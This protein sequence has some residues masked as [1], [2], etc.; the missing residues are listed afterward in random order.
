MLEALGELNIPH[1]LVGPP[2]PVRRVCSL[3]HKEDQGLYYY[4]GEAPGPFA[5][6]ERSVVMC[7]P[8]VARATDSCSAIAIEGAVQLAFYRICARLFVTEPPPGVHPTAIIDPEAR[9][10]AAVHIGPYAVIGKCEIGAGSVVKAHVVVMDGSVIGERVTIE[11]NSCIGATGVA[12]VWAPDGTRIV[13]PQLGGVHIGDEVFIGTDVTVVRGMFNEM[14]TIGAGCMVAHGSKIGHS[15]VLG[16]HCHLANNVSIAGSAK[17]GARSFL[18]A[19]CSIRPHTTLAE[20]TIVGVG[21]AVV[22]DSLTPGAIL[23]GVPARKMPDKE[24]PSG[25]PRPMG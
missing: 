13:L 22:A 8:E 1:R 23:A 12:W 18:G 24:K 4:A 9:I 6:L 15:V 16:E 3:R 10:G 21:A 17:V 2:R 14:T 20:A 11:P 7:R 5:D 19:G 25:M